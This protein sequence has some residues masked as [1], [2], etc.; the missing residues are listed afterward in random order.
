VCLTIGFECGALWRLDSAGKRLVCTETWSAKKSSA[1]KFLERSQKQ[2]LSPGSSGLIRRAWTTAEGVWIPDIS[3]ADDFSRADI[4]LAAGLRSAFAFPIMSG[5]EPCGVLEFYAW[6][7][8]RADEALL[9]IAHSVGAQIGQFLARLETQQRVQTLAHF[10]AMTGL[11]N[12][13]LFQQLLKGAIQQDRDAERGVSL[14]FIDLD[15]FKEINDRYGHDRGD[16]VLVAFAMRLRESLRACDSLARGTASAARFGG[17]E[18]IVLIEGVTSDAILQSIAARVL[19]MAT[20]PFDVQG[21]RTTITASVGISTY[22]RDGMDA[23][24]LVKAADL[25]MYVAKQSGKNRIAFAHGARP[26]TEAG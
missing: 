14:L 18:F 24:Y 22:P 12:R 21:E 1:V 7:P 15:G 3:K 5:K 17:D 13:C 9:S 4:A 23:D 26:V 10:D 20:E 16:H 6:Q 2:V 25:A 19:A 11:P 8:R